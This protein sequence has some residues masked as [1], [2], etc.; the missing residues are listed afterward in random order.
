MNLFLHLEEQSKY[1]LWSPSQE[2][3]IPQRAENQGATRD[4][5]WA[6]SWPVGAY[7][8]KTIP[9]W[10]KSWDHTMRD[11]LEGQRKVSTCTWSP[12]MPLMVRSHG[13]ASFLSDSLKPSPGHPWITGWASHFVA[14]KPLGNAALFYANCLSLEK[15][16]RC[17]PWGNWDSTGSFWHG[18]KEVEFLGVGRKS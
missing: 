3:A 12:W 5:L 13:T 4:C 7:P 2:A 1:L 14:D 18:M 6:H 15:G 10:F 16:H 9:A 17:R 8:H 11:S